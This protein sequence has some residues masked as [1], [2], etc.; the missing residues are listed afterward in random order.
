MNKVSYFCHSI[1]LISLNLCQSDHIKW[2]RLY[3][4]LLGLLGLVGFVEQNLSD[5][6]SNAL[7]KKTSIL[8]MIPKSKQLLCT[9]FVNCK[10][11]DDTFVVF[12]RVIKM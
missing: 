1:N 5:V 3:H 7:Q 10:T 11:K 8:Q 4:Q 12:L 2:L 6:Q 9:I